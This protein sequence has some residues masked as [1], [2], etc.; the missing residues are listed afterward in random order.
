MKGIIKSIGLVYLIGLLILVG[1]GAKGDPLVQAEEALRT[2]KELLQASRGESR[3][4]QIVQ[5]E[6]RLKN[7]LPFL[8]Q[9]DDKLSKDLSSAQRYLQKAHD[10]WLDTI[11]KMENLNKAADTEK[12]RL[13]QDIN[14]NIRTA[15][16]N[17]KSAES[18]IN[19]AKANKEK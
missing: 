2:H 1:C 13:E 19:K 16:D 14:T 9:P 4:E 5:F 8:E 10:S 7:D 18:L 6:S 15:E 11:K 12:A 3:A 17:I